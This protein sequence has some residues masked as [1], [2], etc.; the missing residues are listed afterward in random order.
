MAERL[1]EPGQAL[2][3]DSSMGHAQLAA[4]DCEQAEVLAVTSRTE[5]ELMQSLLSIHKEQRLGTG[6]VNENGPADAKPGR[7]KVSR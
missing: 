5:E 2:Y 1:A 4:K 3:I 6:A 7:G